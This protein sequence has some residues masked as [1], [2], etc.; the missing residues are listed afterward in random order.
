MLRCAGQSGRWEDGWTGWLE[1]PP[2]LST[3]RLLEVSCRVSCIRHE[4]GRRIWSEAVAVGRRV[5]E[6]E[7]LSGCCRKL[8]S[9][10]LHVSPGAAFAIEGAGERDDEEGSGEGKK[11]KRARKKR[12]LGRNRHSDMVCQRNQNKVQVVL[13]IAVPTGSS[14][15]PSS[16]S[17]RRAGVS[18]GRTIQYLGSKSL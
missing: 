17:W 14:R 7:K 11:P 10:R 4:L 3:R 16:Q 1:S 9:A 12:Y 13:C 15:A 18:D 6:G 8:G 2:V 5:G